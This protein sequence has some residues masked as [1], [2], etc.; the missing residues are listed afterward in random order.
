MT[1]PLFVFKNTVPLEEGRELF[2]RKKFGWS[3]KIYRTAITHAT[4]E[5]PL[6]LSLANSAL[7]WKA[8]AFVVANIAYHAMSP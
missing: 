6:R 8:K 7:L 3:S 5:K 1:Q 4:R 2:L